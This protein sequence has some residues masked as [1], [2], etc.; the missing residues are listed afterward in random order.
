M[1]AALRFRRV[2]LLD[3]RIRLRGHEGMMNERHPLFTMDG[4]TRARWLY[5]QVA[6][7]AVADAIV[8]D[9]EAAILHVIARALWIDPSDASELLSI[10]RGELPDPW[11]AEDGPEPVL[12]IG[13]AT[14]YQAA[15]IAAL[16]DE[17][18]TEDEWAMIDVFRSLLGL[19]PEDHALIEEAIRSMAEVDEHG[20]RR[21]E[22]LEAY[23]VA[24][25]LR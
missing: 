12:E 18:I 9:D 20:A 15:L 22:R 14:V 24:H 13:D 1:K 11:E 5:L 25:P 17:V 21:L 3:Q 10:A 6:E 16:D 2:L 7:A 19:Q 8:T 4:N 23:L